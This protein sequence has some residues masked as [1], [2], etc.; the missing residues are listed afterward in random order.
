MA[1]SRSTSV[2]PDIFP[3]VTSM[4]FWGWAQPAATIN[5]THESK[6]PNVLIIVAGNRISRPATLLLLYRANVVKPSYHGL[7]S[8]PLGQGHV[9]SLLTSS[10]HGQTSMP[11]STPSSR[12]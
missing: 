8:L 1:A 7:A 9:T 10:T 6:R 4:Y 11:D 5:S 3:H 12:I 2:S